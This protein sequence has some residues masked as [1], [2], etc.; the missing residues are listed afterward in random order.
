[1]QQRP[2][3]SFFWGDSPAF[4]QR[5]EFQAPKR[6]VLH[7]SGC[8]SGLQPLEIGVRILILT[9]LWL[10]SNHHPC[11][12]PNI[13]LPS[14]E[15]PI[16]R[17]LSALIRRTSAAE[18]ISLDELNKEFAR[19]PEETEA[20]NTRSKSEWGVSTIPY[21]TDTRRRTLQQPAHTHIHKFLLA[22]STLPEILGIPYNIEIFLHWGAC[23][24]AARFGT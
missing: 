17:G 2:E 18:C 13:R 21:S 24:A 9:F 19:L 11:G 14:V 16:G 4:I 22:T 20:Q 8:D 23:F 1:V 6:G 12:R 5:D 3:A 15:S 10:P 7:F